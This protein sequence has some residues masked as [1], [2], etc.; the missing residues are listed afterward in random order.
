MKRFVFLAMAMA[1]SACDGLGGM[2]GLGMGGRSRPPEQYQIAS[3]NGEPLGYAADRQQCEAL[4]AGWFGRADA[5][6]DG[7][8]SDSEMYSDAVQWFRRADTDGS[9]A[10]TVEEL[11]VLRQSLAGRPGAQPQGPDRR[12][13]SEQDRLVVREPDPVMAADINL[14]FRVTEDELLAMAGRRYAQLTRR[15]PADRAAV[16][17][18]CDRKAFR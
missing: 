12:T 4:L 17:A 14:D 11:T 8:I 5:N 7:Q 1:L 9:G 18:D 2:S 10:I 13:R 3:P 15:G 16:V 6:R